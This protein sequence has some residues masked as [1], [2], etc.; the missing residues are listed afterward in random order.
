MKPLLPIDLSV[1]V[2]FV[3]REEVP[4]IVSQGGQQMAFNRSE[5]SLKLSINS[6]VR[7]AKYLRVRVPNLFP[8]LSNNIE[9]YRSCVPP[10]VYLRRLLEY[11][12]QGEYLNQ[13]HKDE[14]PRL[15]TPV[16]EAFNCLYCSVVNINFY[17]SRFTRSTFS[18]NH[19]KPVFFIHFFNL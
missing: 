19:I 16:I 13:H 9:K 3:E 7:L 2:D 8:S 10:R 6:Q 12:N 18:E 1:F 14:S 17:K 11:P 4:E 5:K 15:G